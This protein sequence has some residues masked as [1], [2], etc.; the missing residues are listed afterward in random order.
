M[1]AGRKTGGRARGTPNKVTKSVK[2]ALLTAFRQVGGQRAF[3]KWARE[4]PAVFYGLMAKLLPAE[5]SV[6]AEVE[7]TRDPLTDFEVANRIAFILARAQQPALEAERVEPLPPPHAEPAE[8]AQNSPETLQKPA[9]LPPEPAK[10][11]Y[12][13]IPTAEPPSVDI[14]TYEGSIAEQGRSSTFSPHPRFGPRPV[15]RR[16]D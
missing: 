6:S 16:R 3:T 11:E 7:I 10:P 15:V 14:S 2:D 9:E 4:N 5:L 13:G 1:A 8:I 12:F